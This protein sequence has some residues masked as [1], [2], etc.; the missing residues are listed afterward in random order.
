MKKHLLICLI[1]A[2]SIVAKAQTSIITPSSNNIDIEE[3]EKAIQNKGAELETTSSDKTSSIIG[4]TIEIGSITVNPNPVNTSGI[5]TVNILKPVSNVNIN[6]YSYSGAL[7][8]TIVSQKSFSTSG[9]YYFS[10]DASTITAGNY[11]LAVETKTGKKT[12]KVS[13]AH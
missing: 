3:L 5:V 7:V 2:I 4:I 11:I 12:I 8:K 10:F 9:K 6:L 13:V 1:I